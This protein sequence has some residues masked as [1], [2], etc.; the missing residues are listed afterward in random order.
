MSPAYIPCRTSTSRLSYHI[1][2]L[3]SPNFIEHRGGGGGGGGA[4]GGGRGGGNPP[5]P[6][7]SP[8]FIQPGGGGGRRRREGGREEGGRNLPPP[9]SVL[10]PVFLG[11]LPLHLSSNVVY[12]LLCLPPPIPFRTST[13]C[14][15]SAPLIV[16]GSHGPVP[17]AF[18][19]HT[20]KW[21]EY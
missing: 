20:S 16:P 19:L 17:I 10:R 15:F 8:N 18:K 13:S 21:P 14:P 7:F 9:V 5:P 6:L 3:F 2:P 1:R 11:F 4:G 12:P